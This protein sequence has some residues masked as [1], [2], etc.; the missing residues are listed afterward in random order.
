MIHEVK[1]SNRG[2]SFYYPLIYRWDPIKSSYHLTAYGKS[3]AISGD[4][5]GNPSKGI[6]SK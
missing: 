6:L 3:I 4:I 1:I 5:I 2:K